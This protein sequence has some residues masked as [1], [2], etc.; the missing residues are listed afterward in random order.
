MDGDGTNV[1]TLVH[2][3]VRHEHLN[4]EERNMTHIL[5]VA[6]SLSICMEFAVAPP[7]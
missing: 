7:R 1:N 5:A 2:A 6:R 4:I 3:H